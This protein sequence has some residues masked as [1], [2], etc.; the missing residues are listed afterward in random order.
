MADAATVEVKKPEQ[1]K[2]EGNRLELAEVNRLRMAVTLPEGWAFE[3]CLKPEFWS[4]VAYRFQ[5]EQSFSNKRDWSGRIIEIYTE[6][7]AFYAELYVR[8]VRKTDIIVSVVCEP[9]YFGEKTVSAG[10][11]VRWNVGK[12]KFDILRLIDKEVVA[13]AVTREL[14]AEW[15]AKTTGTMKAA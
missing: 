9:I 8:A 15:I 7:N 4:Q 5:A 2:L 1:R 13:D 12:R 10:Y 11:D 14:A 3:E 6:D